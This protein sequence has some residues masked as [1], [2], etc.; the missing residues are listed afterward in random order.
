MAQQSVTKNPNK[1]QQFLEYFNKVIVPEASS[2]EGKRNKIIT[3]FKV[4]GIIVTGCALLM[5]IACLNPKHIDFGVFF[6]IFLPPVVIL[7]LVPLFFVRSL[8]AISAKKK[9][10]PKLLSFWGEFNYVPPINIYTALY[11]CIKNKTGIGGLLNEIFQDKRSDIS[12]DHNIMSRLLRYENVSFDD[13]ITGRYEDINLELAEFHTYYTTRDS[14][15]NKSKHI[16]FKGV[17]FS[18]VMNKSF[19]GMTAISTTSLDKRRLDRGNRLLIEGDVDLGD[20]FDAG[21]KFLKSGFDKQKLI[22]KTQEFEAAQEAAESAPKCQDVMLEDPEF[23]N[24]FNVYSND[25]VEAR[26]ILTTAFME[27]FKKME[28]SFNGGIKAIF[29]DNKIYI[30]VDDR[31]NWFEIPFFKSATDINNYKE[32]INDFTKL[33]AIIETLKLNENIGL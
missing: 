26:Y 30:L 13:K 8:Y 25:Q 1:A 10:L 14:K 20:L 29:I 21:K 33:L 15:G 6:T 17:C 27:R 28:K 23:K 4:W 12:I 9:I 11:G 5:A 16:T 2:V 24:M 32:F 19:K 7:V 22:Q 31:K 18:A 3:F